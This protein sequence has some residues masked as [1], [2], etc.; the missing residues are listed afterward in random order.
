[1]SARNAP[2]ADSRRWTGPEPS[3][4][5]LDRRAA[6]A[7]FQAAGGRGAAAPQRAASAVS[8]AGLALLP[9]V[10]LAGA[11][12]RAELFGLEPLAAWLREVLEARLSPALGPRDADG[13]VALLGDP[14]LLATLLALAGAFAG[15]LSAWRNRAAL[16]RGFAAAE[17]GVPGAV[18]A[19]RRHREAAPFILLF[20]GWRPLE[21]GLLWLNALA[22]WLV[23]R[24]AAGTLTALAERRAAGLGAR[25]ALSSGWDLAMSAASLSALLLLLGHVLRMFG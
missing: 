17:A 12:A 3:P 13:M 11:D 19:P 21:G 6:R 8:W 23:A 1:M 5:T 15:I 9:L 7:A 14:R 16:A 22:L 2:V 10:V 24:F 20:V 18:F 4:P 25:S